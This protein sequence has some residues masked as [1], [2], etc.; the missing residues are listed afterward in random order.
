MGNLRDPDQHRDGAWDWE[1]LNECWA[2]SRIRASDID[3]IVERFGSFLAFE[4][5]APGEDLEE[6]QRILY[7]AWRKE[8]NHKLLVLRGPK[9]NPY[10]RKTFIPRLNKWSEW[11]PTDKEEIQK[12]CR[13][14]FVEVSRRGR[15]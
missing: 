2:P 7:E 1:F 4:A 10:E 8:G 14:W 3:G 15:R 13:D 11:Q 5:K 9:N 6:G 12:L